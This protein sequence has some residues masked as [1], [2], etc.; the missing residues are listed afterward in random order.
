MTDSKESPPVDSVPC[1]HFNLWDGMILI[2][3]LAIGLAFGKRATWHV[4]VPGMLSVPY[5][6]CLCLES[7][8]VA[9]LLLRSRRPRP[10]LALVV[11]QPG[12]FACG[13]AVVCL[14]ISAIMGV[15]VGYD[16]TLWPIFE[17]SATGGGITSVWL[18]FWLGGLWKPEKGWIDGMGRFLGVCWILMWLMLWV[19]S[20]VWRAI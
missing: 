4:S 20:A 13:T 19:L 12:V 15:L 14:I 10:P 9:V 3:A 5:A 1:R 17:I 2:A 16:H 6:A 7:L 18:M 8:S 11:V